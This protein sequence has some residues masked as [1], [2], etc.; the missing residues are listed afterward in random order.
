MLFKSKMRLSPK[1]ASL[2]VPVECSLAAAEFRYVGAEIHAHQSVEKPF[3]AGW[4]S[5]K[6]ALADEAA[7]IGHGGLEQHVGWLQVACGSSVDAS[8]ET[9]GHWCLPEDAIQCGTMQEALNRRP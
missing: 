2:H 3:V 9:C 4:N 8:C 1:S 7:R 6:G 5:R